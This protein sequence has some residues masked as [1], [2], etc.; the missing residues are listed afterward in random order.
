VALLLRKHGI[1]GVRPLLGGFHEWKSLGYPLVDVS[2]AAG[3][4]PP[5]SSPLAAPEPA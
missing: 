1:R 4:L 5:S 2:E 3:D